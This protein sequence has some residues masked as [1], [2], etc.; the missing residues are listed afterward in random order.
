MSSLEEAQLA[1]ETLNGRDIEGRVLDVREDKFGSSRPL[2]HPPGAQLFISN[3]P[4]TLR[5]QDL[6]DIFRENGF[7]PMHA[8][9][10]IDGPSGRS[11][12]VGVVRLGSRELAEKAI[13]VLNG[14]EVSGRNITV[15]LDKFS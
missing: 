5:W 7:T 8:E 15:R 13:V 14:M 9:V 2:V 4:Y 10:L 6:K 3:L 1:I 11:K 12:G